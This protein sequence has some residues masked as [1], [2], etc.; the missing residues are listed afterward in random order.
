[1]SN[2]QAPWDETP[3][4][5]QNPSTPDETV[6]GKTNAVRKGSPIAAGG[7]R[8]STEDYPETPL[9]TFPPNFAGDHYDPN[10]DVDYNDLTSLGRQINSA[11][12]ALFKANRG[13]TIAQRDEAVS[14]FAY[15]RAHNRAMVSLSGGSEK[16][17]LATADLQTEELYGQWLVKERIVEEMLN[18]VRAMRT[19]L[20]SLTVLS[21]NLRA[22]IN[23][24]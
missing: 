24:Q 21:H 6:E 2:D 17:R 10:P 18:Q 22:Q 20:D 5:G 19:E 3:E 4:T 13:L 16:Q 14:K 15:R 12:K 8:L 7:K 1:M 11:R 23:I 9:P